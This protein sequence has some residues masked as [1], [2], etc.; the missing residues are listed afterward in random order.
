MKKLCLLL[1][2][3][4][5]LTAL[6]AMAAE[7]DA[8][9]G[10]E[11]DNRLSFSY[12]FAVGDT[13]YLVDYAGL[14]TYHVGDSDLK[15]YMIDSPELGDEST[16]YD[17]TTLPFAEGDKLYALNLITEYGE[18]ARYYGANIVELTLT[19]DGNATFSNERSADWSDLI[20][21]YD[22][23][24]YPIRP[25]SIIGAAGKA[26]IRYYNSQEDSY[27]AAAL[28][29]ETGSLSVIDGLDGAM[30]LA[31]Y[32]DDRVL[33]Q[34]YSYES[35][36]QTARLAVYD[37]A[38]DS[39]EMLGK[40]EVEEYSP[41]QGLGYDPVSDA[42]YCIKGGEVCPVD[43]GSGKVGEG[44]TDMPIDAGNM[45]SACVLEGGYFA[46]CSEGAAIRNLDLSQKA[47]S[48]L[49]I[50]DTS[51]SDSISSAYYRFSNAHGDVSVV[52][53]REYS[54]VENL[55]EAMMNRDSSVDIYVLSTSTST[56]DALY[57]R[58]YLMELDGSKKAMELTGDMY[59]S[60]LEDLSMDGHLVAVPLMFNAWS[61]G[62]NTKLLK[63]LN[64]Q[65]DDVPDNW[66]DF[67]DFLPIL[68]DKLAGMNGASLFYS[69]CTV[70]D[71]WD[72]LFSAI[73]EDYQNYVSFTKPGMGYDTDL[74]RGL[75]EK[76]EQIDF[77]ALGCISD[78]DAEDSYFNFSYGDS[79]AL[80]Q[81]STGCNIGNYE[82]DYS[83]VLMRMEPDA[84][85]LLV[86]GT[87]VA[88]V[89]P[90]TKNPEAALAFI[91][92][93]VDN[94]PKALLY[95]LNPNLN[96]AIRGDANQ[97]TLQDSQ[98]ELE[99]LH[100]EYEAASGEE[101][102]SLEQDIANSEAELAEMEANLWEVSPQE[103]EWY[104]AH[105]DNLRIGG[106]NWLYTEE[107]GEAEDLMEQYQDGQISVAD[108]L[109][110]ID[111]KVQMM[112]MEGN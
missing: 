63:A 58:G 99:E 60:L 55:I 33:V 101:K 76:L 112:L 74:L 89:N 90:Y 91:D 19:E 71:A 78:E 7:G 15:E 29:L 10:L 83:C 56:Y 79:T 98:E 110:S 97:E 84:P 16:M 9:L 70:S 37:P 65:I 64:M 68:N 31:A 35:D 32:K 14:Y 92:E 54:D 67:L 96:E 42:I 105:D 13:L 8:M 38:S 47:Q 81:T 21:E 73:I 87:M 4:I 52:L 46:Y 66:S 12:C 23:N 24:S 77:E 5:A 51:W 104:R 34:L 44:V 27:Q 18:T 2:M 88:V 108:M 69:G 11:E 95:G 41:L 80:I 45:A 72:G 20:E 59:P 102:Q 50:N 62:I 85:A 61:L 82:N 6:P 40:V 57:K 22:D 94:L 109:K 26:I 28:D 111:K 25:D 48:K 30:M 43:L 103:I 39:V 1:A 17:I 107:G 93:L 3:L 36:G 75:L 86:L 53:S 100:I 49:K 106:F